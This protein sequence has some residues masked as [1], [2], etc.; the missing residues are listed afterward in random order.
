A[1]KSIN[2][3]VN[4]LLDAHNPDKIQELTGKSVEKGGTAG[5]EQKARAQLKERASSTFTGELIE[6]IEEARKQKFQIIDSTNLD[7]V[8]HVGWDK[9]QKQLSETVAENF[10]AYIREHK[11][12]ITAF[13]IFYDQP[14]RLKEVT[15]Q[16]IK[17]VVAKIKQDKPNLAPLHVWQAYAQLEN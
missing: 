3:V 4:E 9:E 15:Y 7:K 13:K 6:Y 5:D 16:M 17:E 11:D 14:Y 8:T 10:K 2:T 12:E 1:G